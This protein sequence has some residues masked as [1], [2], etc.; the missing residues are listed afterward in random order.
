MI[1]PTP[2]DSSTMADWPKVSFHGPMTKA[3]T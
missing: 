3:S 2:D 1:A